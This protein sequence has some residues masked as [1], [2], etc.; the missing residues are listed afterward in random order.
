MR[1]MLNMLIMLPGFGSSFWYVL[2]MEKA[3]K[4]W[5]TSQ[6]LALGCYWSQSPGCSPSQRTPWH[7]AG[8]R[9]TMLPHA[10]VAHLWGAI[11]TWC[12][13]VSRHSESGARPCT[14]EHLRTQWYS[15][16]SYVV[17]STQLIAE[18]SAIESARDC[19][20]TPRPTAALVGAMAFTLATAVHLAFFHVLGPFAPCS[21]GFHLFGSLFRFSSHWRASPAPH[22]HFSNTRLF[23]AAPHSGAFPRHYQSTTRQSHRKPRWG[24]LKFGVPKTASTGP[25]HRRSSELCNLGS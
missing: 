25:V 16:I 2:V 12:F 3:E 6:K 22:L 24:A 5:T 7:A 21:S 4:H 15:V 17:K 9:G 1:N 19:W 20:A 13:A 10:T 8:Y 11:A 18:K 23:Q 14:S